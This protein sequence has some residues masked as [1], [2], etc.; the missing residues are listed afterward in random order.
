MLLFLML[1]LLLAHGLEG[2]AERAQPTDQRQT[3]RATASRPVAEQTDKEIEA[4]GV[5]DILRNTT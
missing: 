5:H 2:R 3:Q 4:R 1:A